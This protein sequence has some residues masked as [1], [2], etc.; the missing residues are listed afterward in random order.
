MDRDLLEGM[1]GG[2]GGG[3]WI[4]LQWGGRVGSVQVEKKAQ[5]WG[6]QKCEDTMRRMS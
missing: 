1:Q 5:R 4:V 3:L 6:V 2:G